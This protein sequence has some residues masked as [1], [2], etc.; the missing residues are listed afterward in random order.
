MTKV[1][2]KLYEHRFGMF[3]FAFALVYSLLKFE[4]FGIVKA[5]SVTYSLYC[6]DFSLGFCT[7]LLPGAIYKFL[8]GEYNETA[9]SIY[10]NILTVL[11]FA[12]VSFLL[13]KFIKKADNSYKQEAFFVSVF[14]MAAVVFFFYEAGLSRLLDFHWIIATIIFIFCLS[15]KKLY[16]FMPLPIVYALMTHYVSLVCYVPVC[17]LIL[18]LKIIY[19]EEKK[20]KAF[21]SVIFSVSLITSVALF[22]YMA[23]F[24]LENVKLSYP[25]FNSILKERG[26]LNTEYYNFAFFRENVEDIFESYY[27]EETVGL[28]NNI[29]TNQSAINVLLQTI[30]QQIK[31]NFYLADHRNGLLKVS[32]FLVLICFIFNGTWKSMKSKKKF[33]QLI[34]FC[35]AI[36]F[37]VIC[38]IGLLFSTDT[39]RW[40]G[41][42][43]LS[44]VTIYIYN[45]YLNKENGKKMLSVISEKPKG[46][47]FLSIA[48]VLVFLVI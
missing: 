15:N 37:T 2:E 44:L 5:Q 13:D 24:E 21:L 33:E 40:L 12:A 27:N 6:V 43:I 34:L 46:L 47:Y 39:I 41:N 3:F 20:E 8:V 14:T 42:A 23:L 29:D 22:G 26:V 10:V 4:T 32:V 19:T 1:K 17:L 11:A 36:L 35:P 31:I 48:I 30:A 18:L 25:T 28:V 7:K 9:I 45:I 16:I 38:M